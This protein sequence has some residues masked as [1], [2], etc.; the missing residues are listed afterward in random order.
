[1]DFIDLK[2]EQYQQLKSWIYKRPT[3]AS[4]SNLT[5]HIFWN[6]YYQSKYCF[7]PKG[8]LCF[9]KDSKK[10]N[11]A[12]PPIS[13]LEDM[14]ELFYQMQ[15]YFTEILHA[16]F[17]MAL[18]DE[19]ALKAIQPP[20]E[21]YIIIDETDPLGDYIYSAE[22]LRTLSGK[23]LHR[24]KTQI[25]VFKKQYKECYEYCKFSKED[26]EELIQFLEQWRNS[27]VR[28]D[29]T[30]LLQTEAIGV[31]EV[32]KV[33]EECRIQI[34][35]IKINEELK[36]FAIGSY[37]KETDMVVLHVEKADTSIKG[38]YAFMD[39]QF[40]VREFPNAKYVNREEDMGISGMRIAKMSY[41]PLYKTKKYRI[42]EKVVL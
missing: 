15:T 37:E 5:Y 20:E 12:L 32:L 39:Q 8:V 31:K 34:S 16:P 13:K 18:L 27:K 11:C 23:K 2:E 26:T 29:P 42:V 21:G 14:K 38:M 36:A 28:E 1:M 24:K 19:E 41:R 25:N 17:Q 6:H 35:G 9:V 33:M 30:Q 3:M 40:L 10:E 7:T 22:Q 4:E